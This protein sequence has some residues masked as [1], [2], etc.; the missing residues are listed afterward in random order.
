MGSDFSQAWLCSCNLH[1][2]FIFP[3]CFLVPL[4]VFLGSVPLFNDDIILLHII[5]SFIICYYSNKYTLLLILCFIWD[6]YRLLQ[7][8][9]LSSCEWVSLVQLLKMWTGWFPLCHRSCYVISGTAGAQC[10]V[11]WP[12]SV[13]DNLL[14]IQV[15][16]YN[17]WH[18]ECTNTIFWLHCSVGIYSNA[19]MCKINGMKITMSVLL[20]SWKKA[21]YLT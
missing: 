13:Q 9:W 6:Y 2:L 21:K 17:S 1:I 7:V 15:F 19:G 12:D 16:H 3:S 20:H 5:I 11:L 8:T 14:L 18:Q 10:K 4:H